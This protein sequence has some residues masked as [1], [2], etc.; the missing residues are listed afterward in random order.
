LG[1]GV[2]YGV[3]F[4]SR[5]PMAAHE[6]SIWL[7][8]DLR[9]M[10]CLLRSLAR[11]GRA[12]AES[13][14][15]AQANARL[16][17]RAYARPGRAG[18][19][20]RPGGGTDPQPGRCRRRDRH[21]RAR[22]RGP[23]SA[24]RDGG[25]APLVPAELRIDAAGPHL[26]GAGKAARGQRAAS[27]HRATGAIPAGPRSRAQDRPQ[28]D[29]V[30]PQRLRARRRRGMDGRE[31]GSACD[32]AEAAPARRRELSPTSSNRTSTSNAHTAVHPRAGRS[33]RQ[34]PVGER[35]A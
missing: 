19:P 9:E 22:G 30:S 23:A 31:P 32:P 21:S 11:T 13:P 18:V 14:A 20:A 29:H 4:L 7:R 35:C 8:P 26:A 3:Q 2:Q 33:M 25:R 10:W 12:P 16:G 27:G 34:G 17:R 24:A 6:A 15:R 28:H 1:H 5:A